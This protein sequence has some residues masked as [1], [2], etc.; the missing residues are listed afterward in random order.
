LLVIPEEGGL[1]DIDEIRRIL[2]EIPDVWNVRKFSRES[3]RSI[4]CS[5]S[6][7]EDEMLVDVSET[8]MAVSHV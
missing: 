1:W 2:L 5:Y 3:G 8:Y 4:Q 6:Y 7:A